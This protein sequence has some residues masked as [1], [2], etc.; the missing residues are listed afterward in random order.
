[1]KF[2]DG[3]AVFSSGRRARAYNN[4]IGLTPGFRLTYGFD[5]VFMPQ[6]QDSDEEDPEFTPQEKAEIADYMISLWRE[7]KR[8]SEGK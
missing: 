6:W 8:R 3:V 5:G 2:E 4:V 1:M 7:F